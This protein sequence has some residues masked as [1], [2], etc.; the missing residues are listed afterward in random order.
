MKLYHWA[1]D[2]Q[3]IF[4][5]KGSL[6]RRLW[7]GLAFLLGL[8]LLLTYLHHEEIFVVE[9][10]LSLPGLLGVVIGL[11]LVF[12]NNSAYDRWW[13]ARKILGGLVNTSRNFAMQL[14]SLMI[15]TTEADRKDAHQLLVAFVFALKEHLRGGV[16]IEE[17]GLVN[18]QLAKQVE[19][20]KHKPNRIIQ[21]LLGRIRSLYDRELV[22]DFQM[23]KLIENT[24]ELID[25]LGKCERIHNTPIPLSHN[26]LLRFCVL[27]YSLI[28][29]FGLIATLDWWSFI[30]VMLIFYFMMS[31][32]IIAEEIEDPF[33][34]DANDLPVDNIAQNIKNNLDEIFSFDDPIVDPQANPPN[35]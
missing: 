35:F 24:D 26:Y 21:L 15:H 12:R 6:L 3:L 22:T 17:L 23:L 28:L 29:P 18:P 32:I 8:T 31:I 10:S 27:F 14:K 7:P 20:A 5:F 13:E 4:R 25:I 2:L 30:V 19:A 34:L 9:I 1:K 33:G 11:L 16:K